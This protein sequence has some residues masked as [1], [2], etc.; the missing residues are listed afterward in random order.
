[1]ENNLHNNYLFKAIDAYPFD[2]AE[3]L[4][5]LSYA[6]S[7]DAHNVEALYLMGVVYAEQLQDY[8]TAISYFEEAV[9][10]KIDSP[11]IYPFYILTLINNE[12]YE[13][14]QKLIDFSKTMK[15]SDKAH[16]MLLQAVLFESLLSFKKAKKAYQKALRMGMNNHFISHVESELKRVEKK[17]KPKSKSKKKKKAKK[18]KK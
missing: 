2:L 10:A 11:K 6:L 14:A 5:S 3:A 4:E 12:D 8:K 18:C 9:A 7:Y 1:M 15:G 16:L 17:M 13:H